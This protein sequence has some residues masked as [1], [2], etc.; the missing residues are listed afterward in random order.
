MPGSGLKTGFS[1]LWQTGS[2]D[3]IDTASENLVEVLSGIFPFL[4]AIN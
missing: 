3:I 4:F 1:V 2:G